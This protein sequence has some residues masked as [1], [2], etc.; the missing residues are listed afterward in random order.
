MITASVPS[1]SDSISILTLSVV[2]SSI[3]SPIFTSSPSCFSQ[4]TIVP[5]SMATPAFGIITSTDIGS[6]PI[7]FLIF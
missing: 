3:G 7:Y 6:P 4:D 2:I 1:P 5:S